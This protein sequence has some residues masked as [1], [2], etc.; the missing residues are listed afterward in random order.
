[1]RLAVL[2]DIHSNLPAFQ[3]VLKKMS[4]IYF[5]AVW[6]A[7]DFVGYNPFPNE[8]IAEMKKENFFCVKGNHDWAVETSDTSW[9]NPEAAEAI[10]WTM[11]RITIGNK[12]WL[13]SLPS[14]LEKKIGGKVVSMVHGSPA[15]E[16]FEYVFPEDAKEKAPEWLEKADA[17]ILGH[18][19]VPINL[20]IKVRGK[21]KI[22]LN[23]GA[24]GQPRDGDSRASFALLDLKKMNAE[25]IRV[26]Y[27]TALVKKKILDEGLPS[28]LGERLENGL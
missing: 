26:R 7:G 20:P 2:S 22:L 23:P 5:D 28:W 24:V 10:R 14:R 15:D 1:M 12:E 19:H 13:A 11:K 25:I 18:T 8:V 16:L 4:R 21:R 9:F 3:A 6:C 17:L 27:D